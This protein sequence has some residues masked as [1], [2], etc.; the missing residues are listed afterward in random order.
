MISMIR[1]RFSVKEY[2]HIWP[3][4]SSKKRPH[5]VLGVCR[6]A[7]MDSAGNEGAEIDKAAPGLF[8]PKGGKI[9][10]IWVELSLEPIWRFMNQDEKTTPKAGRPRLRRAGAGS[11]VVE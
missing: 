2:R 3:G 4:E 1:S 9:E 8:S 11:W 5:D 6:G 7:K 10:K